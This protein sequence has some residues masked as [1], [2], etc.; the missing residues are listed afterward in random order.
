[1]N[2]SLLYQPLKLI[3]RAA[4]AIKRNRRFKKLQHTPAAQL[5][6]GHIDS[7]ELLEI[8]R[9]DAALTASPNIYDIGS[10]VGTW[11]LLAKAIFPNARVDA[12]EP[13][14]DHNSQ[15]TNSC[16]NLS[17]IHL[18]E[19]CLGNE[20]TAGV[21]NIS[22][23]SD[24]S[25]LLVA[26]PLEF[27]HF[28]IKKEKELPVEIKR[29]A[30]LIKDKT[31]PVPDIIKLDIQGFELEALKG[32]D[33]YLNKVTY[34]ICEVSF[35]EYYYGQPGFLEIANYLAGFNIHLFA[36]GNNTPIGIELNQI[37]VL[38]KRRK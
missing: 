7:L 15:F 32:L 18:H 14:P 24:S 21:I 22:S 17:D 2:Y 4:L 19:F 3:E 9:D 25:S 31:I 5:G 6:L 13:L 38:F 8:I 20:D 16:K 10:N 35:K 26:T 30:G 23:Y 27:E 1:M 29:L 36:F 12:F 34:I 37:D 28:N 33:T 11:T